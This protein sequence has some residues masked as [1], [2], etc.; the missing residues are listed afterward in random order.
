MAGTIL[1]R[2]G[3]YGGY[4]GHKVRLACNLKAMKLKKLRWSGRRQHRSS[5]LQG[6]VQDGCGLGPIWHIIVD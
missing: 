5:R 2:V 6:R 3:C 4:V 1:Q